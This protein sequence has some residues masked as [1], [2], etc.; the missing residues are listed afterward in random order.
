MHL[1][2]GLGNPGKK[3]D[4]TRHNV[5]FDFIDKLASDYNIQFKTNKK[6]KAEVG[7]GFIGIHKVILVK[8]S[9]YMNLSGEAVRAVMDYYGVDYDDIIVV[10]DDMDL[11][12]GKIKLRPKGS[13]GGHNGIKSIIS[14]LG[15]QEFKRIKVGI[16]KHQFMST[17]D[18]VLGKFETENRLLIDESIVRSIMATKSYLDST[19][20]DAMNNYNRK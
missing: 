15:T 6:Q 11:D 20:T 1:I 13:S 18:Y 19:F 8:P 2:V 4:K 3:Y 7:M 9:T 10:Y 17:V 5:G 12:I 16:G 14:H